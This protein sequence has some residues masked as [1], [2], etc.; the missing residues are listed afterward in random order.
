MPS[1]KSLKNLTGKGRFATSKEIA[2]EA[3]K[4]SVEKRKENKEK[5]ERFLA[6][7]E[8][9]RR[10]LNEEMANGKTFQENISLIIKKR[11]F[12][13]ET[14]IADVIK[15]LEF[16]LNYSGQ[17]SVGKLDITNTNLNITDEKVI[18]EVMEKIKEL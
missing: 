13:E 14:K 10:T 11:A 4:K 12:E 1:E 15:I 8:V 2:K 9:A 17:T 6:Y 7:S 3:Q 18:N 16:L 5:R